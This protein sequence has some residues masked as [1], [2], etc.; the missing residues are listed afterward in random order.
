M[1]LGMSYH[2]HSGYLNSNRV[3]IILTVQVQAIGRFFSFTLFV[4]CALPIQKVPP[5]FT[6]G[7]GPRIL[8]ELSF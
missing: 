2:T 6:A 4:I 8:C 7:F 1:A 3:D 5:R